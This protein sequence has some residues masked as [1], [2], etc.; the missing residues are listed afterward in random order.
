MPEFREAW[1]QYYAK[2][3]LE[4]KKQGIDIFSLTVQNEPKAVQSWDSCVYTPE[5]ERDFVKDYLGPAL[6]AAGLGHVKVMVWDHNKERL[7][8]WAAV[9]LSDEKAAKYLF[10]A[11]FHWY[12]G[13]HFEAIEA[14]NARFPDMKFIFTEGCQEGGVKLGAHL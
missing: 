3:I 1:A 4:M 5:E 6:E 2:Y 7:Y 14:L 12:S 9:S 13:D 8:D 10:G 11:G